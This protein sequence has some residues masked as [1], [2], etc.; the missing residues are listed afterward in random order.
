MFSTIKA[1]LGFDENPDTPMLYIYNIYKCN[2]YIYFICLFYPGGII[3]GFIRINTYYIYIYIYT[4]KRCC[5]LSHMGQ[6]Q[7]C[8][9]NTNNVRLIMY[10][11]KFIP[12]T[13]GITKQPHQV[14]DSVFTQSHFISPPLFIFISKSYNVV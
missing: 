4:Y 10:D 2:V 1:V 8:N 11:K 9:N 6:V 5:A 13:S 12:H 14:L 7:K 3:N